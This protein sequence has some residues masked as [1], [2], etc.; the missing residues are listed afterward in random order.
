VRAFVEGLKSPFSIGL[1]LL[2]LVM[3]IYHSVTWLN[4]APKAL[5][6]WRGEERVPPE[7]IIAASYGVWIVLSLLVAGIVFAAGRA[8]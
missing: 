8:G 5:V 4:A 1:H 6:F 7:T 3:A 2:T